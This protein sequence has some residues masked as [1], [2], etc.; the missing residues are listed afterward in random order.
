MVTINS[1]E[2]LFSF[3]RNINHSIFFVG[4]LDCQSILTIKPF[5]AKF[6]VI[7]FNDP[8]SGIYPFI[9]VPEFG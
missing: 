6:E 3:C 7:T 1:I 2:E 8:Y 4:S 5:L 9:K